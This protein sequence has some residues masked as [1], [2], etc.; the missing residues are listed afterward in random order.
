MN[1]M[2]LRRS[3]INIRMLFAVIIVSVIY[4][5]ELYAN[6]MFMSGSIYNAE[7]TVD[8]LGLLIIAFAFSI[9]PTTAGLFPGIPY[10][11]SLLEE[12]N[13]GFMRY[14]L[15][16]MSPMRYIRKKYCFPVWQVPA[17]CYFRI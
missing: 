4:I 10:S 1:K 8:I 6:G 3:I 12:R 16:R 9:M 5:Y 2:M 15:L 14:E 7:G 17:R 13:S 11:F